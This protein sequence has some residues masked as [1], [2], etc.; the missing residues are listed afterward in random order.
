MEEEMLEELEKLIKE[1]YGGFIFNMAVSAK[2]SLFLSCWQQNSELTDNSFFM[3][4]W[5]TFYLIGSVENGSRLILKLISYNGIIIDS[6][7]EN[8]QKITSEETLDF[9]EKLLNLELCAGIQE[10]KEMK[11]DFSLCLIDKLQQNV[12]VRS[13]H[14]N[15][16]LNDGTKICDPCRNLETEIS[17]EKNGRKLQ[18][19]VPTKQSDPLG[20]RNMA[21]ESVQTTLISDGFLLDNIKLEAIADEFIKDNED[22]KAIDRHRIDDDALLYGQSFDQDQ[23]SKAM[24]ESSKSSKPIK[25][26]KTSDQTWNSKTP[27][28][29]KIKTTTASHLP[30]IC[31]ESNCAKSY[32]SYKELKKHYQD[33]GHRAK[34]VCFLCGKAVQRDV[35]LRN[36]IISVHLKLKPYKCIHCFFTSALPE[37]IYNGHYKRMHGNG[38]NGTKLDVVSIP[39]VMKAIH[40]F[41]EENKNNLKGLSMIP[42]PLEE[43]PYNEDDI[44]E[45]DPSN[46]TRSSI[47]LKTARKRKTLL[48]IHD[49]I[50]KQAL[51]KS[52][53]ANSNSENFSLTQKRNDSDEKQLRIIIKKCCKMANNNKKGKLRHQCNTCLLAYDTC[54]SFENDQNKHKQQMENKELVNCPTCAASVFKVKLNEHYD[55][56][57]PEL[58]AGCCLECQAVVVP[59]IKM[60]RHF[61]TIHKPKN[62]C[63][64]CGKYFRSVKYHMAVKH[65]KNDTKDHKC[66]VCGKSFRHAL[67]LKSH[68]AKIHTTRKLFP[69]KLCG[70]LFKEKC[71]LATHYWSTHMK[72]KPYKVSR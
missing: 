22:M 11:I 4:Y 13:R 53:E 49:S 47:R 60:Q 32:H 68:V 19:P 38:E 48:T 54:E 58:K 67:L 2:G 27:K 8:G 35:Y 12:F 69:C 70:I 72:V 6:L 65:S 29:R 42:P 3:E 66:E 61:E 57:H 51:D 36:H 37:K 55:K 23:E 26:D 34:H 20:I 33:T 39:E 63:P 1:N 46:S 64:I 43:L 7:G 25:N 14:C 17:Y 15:F 24:A 18:M 62:E 59:K 50:K 16:G 10:A 44:F 71:T 9:I 28:R 52:G 40:D 41:G 45:D 5:P 56:D 30:H 31:S 21:Q